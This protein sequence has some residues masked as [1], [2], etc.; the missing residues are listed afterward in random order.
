MY[1]P[2]QRT[3]NSYIHVRAQVKMLVVDYNTSEPALC[4]NTQFKTHFVDFVDRAL[5]SLA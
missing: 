3:K 1:R 5:N 2:K 4:L